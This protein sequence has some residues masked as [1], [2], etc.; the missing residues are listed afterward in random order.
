MNYNNNSFLKKQAQFNVIFAFIL[1]SKNYFFSA[2][3]Q[4]FVF[5]FLITH[6]FLY[7]SNFKL[8]LQ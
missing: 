2:K 8:A 3:P 1:L 7:L 6:M 4:Y 5:S